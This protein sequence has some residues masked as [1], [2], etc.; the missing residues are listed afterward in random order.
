MLYRSGWLLLGDKLGV[1]ARTQAR[2]LLAVGV[3]LVVIRISYHL[4]QGPPAIAHLPWA[5]AT[6]VLY[7]RWRRLLP[8]VIAHF[9][10]DLVLIGLD[11][12]PVT[13]VV[14]RAA[15]LTMPLILLGGLL[16]ISDRRRLAQVT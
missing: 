7:V 5:V 4:D 1:T 14:V 6:V 11:P 12:L 13:N 9:A 15:I 10:T 16:V 2:M 3:A 8:I